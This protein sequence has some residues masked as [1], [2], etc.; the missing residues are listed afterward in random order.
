MGQ[1]AYLQENQMFHSYFLEPIYLANQIAKTHICCSFY[2]NSSISKDE[3]TGKTLTKSSGTFTP[4]F[5]IFCALTTAP[6]SPGT[7]TNIDLQRA[8]KLAL[9]LF[10]K[11]QEYVQLQAILD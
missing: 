9:E 11:G 6:G 10:I 1:V 2:Q 3:F 8:I 4:I 7:Y 5:V